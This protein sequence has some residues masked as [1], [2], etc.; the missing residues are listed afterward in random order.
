MDLFKSGKFIPTQFTIYHHQYEKT[1]PTLPLLLASFEDD[2]ISIGQLNAFG[3]VKKDQLQL[4]L[5]EV[6]SIMLDCQ[7]AFN[8]GLKSS[9]AIAHFEFLL[10]VT[11]CLK[12]KEEYRLINSSMIL[13]H[14][15]AAY[16]K[17]HLI[18]LN[19]PYHL[20]TLL[21]NTTTDVDA[22]TILQPLSNQFSMFMNK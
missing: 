22:Y 9:T 11:I 3:K 16:C 21:D 4:P 7:K 18:T 20:V 19:D 10:G 8:G 5:D 12:S 17:K 6:E 2:S 1:Y 14:D 15:L 13:I